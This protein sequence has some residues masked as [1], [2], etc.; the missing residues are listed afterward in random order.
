MFPKKSLH[1][2]RGF[3]LIGLLIVLAIIGMLMYKELGPDEKGVSQAIATI[4]RSKVAACTVNRSTF[5]TQIIAWMA[6]HREEPMTMENLNKAGVTPPAC[7]EGGKL[8]FDANGDVYCSVHAPENA[9]DSG[10]AP[11]DPGMPSGG[12]PQIPAPGQMP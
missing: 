8:S 3:Y 2:Q 9:P 6:M 12:I 7:P 1:S 5:H 4:D 11:A 10:G